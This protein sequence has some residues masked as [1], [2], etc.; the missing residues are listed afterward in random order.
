MRAQL[1]IDLSGETME[2]IRIAAEKKGISPGI[3]VRMILHEKFNRID[4]NA[5]SKTYT[6]TTRSWRELEAFIKVRNL[7]SVEGFAPIAM[8]LAMSRNKLSKRQKA[9]FEKILGS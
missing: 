2:A 6:F 1:R 8:D 7:G 9:D 3:F 4:D 5:E